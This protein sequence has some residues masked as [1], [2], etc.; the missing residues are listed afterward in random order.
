M[1]ESLRHD[2]NE[3][4]MCMCKHHIEYRIGYK[5]VGRV[6]EIGTRGSGPAGYDATS[7][8]LNMSKSVSR[9]TWILPDLRP[10]VTKTESQ[11]FSVC[12]CALAIASKE[13]NWRWIYYNRGLKEDSNTEN[14]RM[15][16]NHQSAW[17]SQPHAEWLTTGLNSGSHV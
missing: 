10:H 3:S 2:M 14:I 11:R 15:V 6:D 17:A 16:E 5:M 9:T 13:K 4:Y 7:W 12:V 1:L 8:W